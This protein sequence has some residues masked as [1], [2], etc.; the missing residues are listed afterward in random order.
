MA[1]LVLDK[2]ERFEHSH[3]HISTSELLEGKVKLIMGEDE[4]DMEVN[5]V[6]NIPENT[7]HIMVNVGNGKAKIE[8]PSH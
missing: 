2:G 8:C 7:P 1:I 4:I 6:I 3:K 5:K